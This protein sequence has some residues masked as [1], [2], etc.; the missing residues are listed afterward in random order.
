MKEEERPY[1]TPHP[2]AVSLR[3]TQRRDVRKPEHEHETLPF[4]DQRLVCAPGV[5]PE[6]E[7]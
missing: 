4:P 2:A 1:D 7:G 5:D 6:N 3:N